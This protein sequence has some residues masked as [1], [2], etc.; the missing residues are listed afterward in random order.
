M[1]YI[2]IRKPIFLNSRRLQNT[3]LEHDI[4][5]LEAIFAAVGLQQT[6]EGKLT[7][8][9]ER[10]AFL[11]ISMGLRIDNKHCKWETTVNFTATA[12]PGDNL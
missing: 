3:G 11:R 4:F 5:S 1:L 10:I 2:M 7:K 9:E 12:G 6:L 8:V